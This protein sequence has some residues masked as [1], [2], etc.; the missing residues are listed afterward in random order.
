MQYPTID[1]PCLHIKSSNPLFVGDSGL[2][3]GIYSDSGTQ[4]CAKYT[5]SLGYEIPDAQQFA[6]WGVDLLK[7]DNCFS[8]P[9]SVVSSTEHRLCSLLALCSPCA[10]L[11]PLF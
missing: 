2:K 3:L 5:A 1:Q 10:H 7:Y 9:A 11:Q 6:D 4:T 8:V